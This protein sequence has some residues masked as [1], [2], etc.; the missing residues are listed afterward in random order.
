M[1]ENSSCINHLY[2]AI[3]SLKLSGMHSYAMVQSPCGV[4]ISTWCPWW[5]CKRDIDN[6]DACYPSEEILVKFWIPN[7]TVVGENSS[8]INHL[9][10]VCTSRHVV[11]GEIV[12]A[13]LITMMRVKFWISNGT[14]VGENSSSINHLY[15]VCTSRH[16]VLGEIVNATLIT[17][18]RVIPPREFSSSEYPNVN[19]NWMNH[20]MRQNS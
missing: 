15:V 4:H 10:G 6:Y 2:V 13:T 19:C 18:M 3:P 11:L 5:D 7:G 14:V 1:G 20:V 8:S 9:Y 16:D 17:M 12:N